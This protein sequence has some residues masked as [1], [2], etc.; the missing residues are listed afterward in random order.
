M[1]TTQL[2]QSSANVI[3][4]TKL[5]P[6]DL[7][8]R[9]DIKETYSEDKTYYGIVAAIHND[10]KNTIIQSTEYAQG[11]NNIEAKNK[12]IRGTEEI[13]IFPCTL[14]EF[15][16]EFATCKEMLIRSIETHKE[17]IASKNNKIQ[18]LDNLISREKQKQLTE[19]S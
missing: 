16:L 14:E 19:A 8:K 1:N 5:K 4:I 6:G 11:Y 17:A 7:Y 18:E 9:F 10:G 12:I 3:R 13:A 2:I 15:N